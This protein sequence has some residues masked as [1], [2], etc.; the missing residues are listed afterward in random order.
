MAETFD[1]LLSRIVE[2]DGEDLGEYTVKKAWI[3]PA[4]L[5]KLNKPQS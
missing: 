3:D 4:L 2:T 1:E 5:A